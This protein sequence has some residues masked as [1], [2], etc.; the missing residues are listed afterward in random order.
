MVSCAASFGRRLAGHDMWL[1]GEHSRE[2][3]R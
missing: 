1:K 2:V 3:D